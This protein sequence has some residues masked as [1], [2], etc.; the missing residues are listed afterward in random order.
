MSL[1]KN[2]ELVELLVLFYY[3]LFSIVNKLSSILLQQLPQKD[4]ILVSLAPVDL[5][6]CV[7]NETEPV[8]VTACP[9][10]KATHMKVVVTN[11]NSI[12]IVRHVSLAF[13]ISA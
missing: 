4:Q 2:L 9:V 12:P 7:K 5:M 1:H 8:H 6:Q 11:V 3:F 13:K 10:S